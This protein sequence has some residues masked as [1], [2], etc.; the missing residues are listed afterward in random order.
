VITNPVTTV[1]STNT[2]V[3]ITQTTGESTPAI[4]S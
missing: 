1:V 3:V 4:P 2:S